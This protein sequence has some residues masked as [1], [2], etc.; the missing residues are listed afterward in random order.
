M[1]NLKAIEKIKLIHPQWK[2]SQITIT[3]IHT[4]SVDAF[5]IL[6]KFSYR[7]KRFEYREDA[8]SEWIDPVSE[9]KEI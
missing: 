7:G 4:R 1:T 8:H 9:R 3:S 5:C 6:I 2:R